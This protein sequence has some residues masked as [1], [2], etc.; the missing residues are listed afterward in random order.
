MHTLEM[1]IR[2]SKNGY[3]C[4]VK[5]DHAYLVQNGYVYPVEQKS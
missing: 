2:T 1:N 3:A 5:I 4:P